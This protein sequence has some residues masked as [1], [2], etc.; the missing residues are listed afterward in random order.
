MA[1]ATTLLLAWRQ[2]DEAALEQLI[3][4]VYQALRR[5]AH[6]YM[7]GQRAGHTLQTTALV[8]ETY[9]QLVDYRQVRWQDRSHFLAVSATLMRRILVDYARSRN[10]GK[11]GGAE[12]PLSFDENLTFSPAASA[13]LVALDDALQALGEIDPRKSKVVELKFFG[14]LDTREIAAALGVSEPTVLRDWKLAKVW[15]LREVTR[16]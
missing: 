1:D 12:R 6:R 16:T 5:M 9:L 3:P 14:G 15:L 4:L 10:A 7:A 2:G 11:R 13:N 8:H